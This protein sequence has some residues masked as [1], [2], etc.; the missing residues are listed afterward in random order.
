[1]S[2]GILQ[3]TVH[4]LSENKTKILIP[5]GESEDKS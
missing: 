3:L 5:T 1:M 4:M 2:G